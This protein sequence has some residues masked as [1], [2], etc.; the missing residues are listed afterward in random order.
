MS[1]LLLMKNPRVL[2]VEMVSVDFIVEMVSVDFI[3]E[4]VSVE[5][6]LN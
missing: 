6:T 1:L 5:F 3:V 4:M 2:F